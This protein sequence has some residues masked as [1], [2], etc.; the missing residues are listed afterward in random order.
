M[1][2]ALILSAT[3]GEA[4]SC[5]PGIEYY[6]DQTIRPNLTAKT[7][8]YF[9][10]SHILKKTPLVY[11]IRSPHPFDLYVNFRSRCPDGSEAPLARIPGKNK[12]VRINV[13]VDPD[14]TIIVNGMYSEQDTSL[15]LSLLGQSP[16]RRISPGVKTAALFLVMSVSA[17]TYFVKC[18][19]PPIKP[20]VD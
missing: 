5:P 4:A 15:S 14:A 18:V 12:T 1:F 3:C 20:K 10:T 11:K 6:F 2:F 16:P 17:V 19:L 13:P 8:Y 9:H 7:W